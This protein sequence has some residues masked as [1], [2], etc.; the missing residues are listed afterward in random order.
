MIPP[1]LR[2]SF[3]DFNVVLCE[4]RFDGGRIGIV[5]AIHLD[6]I[7]GE[8]SRDDG[9][10]QPGILRSDIAKGVWNV[11]RTHHDRAGGGG[12]LLLADGDL[13]PAVQDVEDFRFVVMNATGI[14]CSKIA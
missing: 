7:V 14:F 6:E 4:E 10:K 11:A 1:G 3:D 2:A 9:E 12:Q 13:E 5:Y 8:P